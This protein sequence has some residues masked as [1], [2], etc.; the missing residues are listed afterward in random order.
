MRRYPPP[1]PSL[2]WIAFVVAAI[3]LVFALSCATSAPASSS[4]ARARAYA[5]VCDVFGSRC[6]SAMRVVACETGGT[7]DRRA[8]GGAGERGLFQIHPVHFG[9]LDEGRLF[10]RRYNARIAFRLSRGGRD[11]RP[12]T[13][14]P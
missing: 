7:Y 13:C 12:W 5:A 10:E 6:S 9:W 1:P 4:T 11:W 8:V 14:R 3:V 2:G